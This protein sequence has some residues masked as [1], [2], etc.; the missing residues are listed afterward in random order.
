[1]Q[2][3]T[4]QRRT[5]AIAALS[6]AAFALPLFL[7]GALAVQIRSDFAFNVAAMGVMIGV[8][9]GAGAVTSIPLGR[10]ADRLGATRS[11]AAAA[12][13]SFIASVGV[14]LAARS[15]TSLA[16]WLIL[17]SA[18]NSL[19]LPG[20]NRLL[21]RSVREE[22]RGL[23]FG[24]K[25]SA[26]PMATMLAGLSVP[27]IALT[28]GWRWAFVL[29]AALAALLLVVFAIRA[30]SLPQG[31]KSAPEKSRVSGASKMTRP[32]TL[33]VLAAGIFCVMVAATSLAAFFVDYAV[34]SG[35]PEAFAGYG[36]AGASLATVCV[37]LWAG[38]RADKMSESHLRLCATLIA[39][40][41]LGFILMA[42]TGQLVFV[43]VGALIALPAGW[44]SNG[45]FWYALTNA[46][47]DRP[48]A[49]TGIVR[50]GALL[51]GSLGPLALG[52][53]ITETSYRIAW[54]A[55]AGV[56]LIAASAMVVGD[57][58]LRAE[59]LMRVSHSS[60]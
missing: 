54:I 49:V 53:L 19:G 45:V 31:G 15:W 14:A 9:R 23:A 20:T 46:N 47:P 2:N 1:M 44:G 5:V 36:L 43:F 18:A 16:A 28:I 55:S 7:V 13:V 4:S 50:P 39:A 12:F 17:S 35:S 57:R 41:A 48:G 56:C 27:A 26:P 40:G 51:G 37:R 58:R 59:S 24:I 29:V 8:S 33:V 21:I 42:I 11:L 34:S 38:S 30:R 52:L 3:L 10:L 32:S 6:S 25:Q 60:N 22:R